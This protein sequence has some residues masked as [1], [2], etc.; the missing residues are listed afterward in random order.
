MTSPLR[1]L[2]KD[3]T[4]DA[5]IIDGKIFAPGSKFDGLKATESNLMKALDNKGGK[6]TNVQ[7]YVVTPNA[8]EQ[9][10]PDGTPLPMTDPRYGKL[11]PG[12]GT[13]GIQT[14]SGYIPPTDQIMQDGS[15]MKPDNEMYNQTPGKQSGLLNKGQREQV[16]A[17]ATLSQLGLV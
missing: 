7:D 5:Q 12:A 14:G 10:M 13:G 3:R 2:L 4:K 8:G 9:I 17:M 15:R 16:L 1:L 6:E 11:P